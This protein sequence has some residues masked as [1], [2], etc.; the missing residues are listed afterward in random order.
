MLEAGRKKYHLLALRFDG[1]SWQGW[2]IPKK[3]KTV[4]N[5]TQPI[6]DH[7]I[8]VE[9]CFF[10][11][12]MFS[13]NRFSITLGLIYC[14]LIECCGATGVI[15]L[16]TQTMHCYK[17]ITSTLHRCVVLDSSKVGNLKTLVQPKLPGMCQSFVLLSNLHVSFCAARKKCWLVVEPTHL[18]NIRQDGFIFPNFRGENKKIFELPPASYSMFDPNLWSPTSWDLYLEKRRWKHLMENVDFWH[19]PFLISSLAFWANHETFSDETWQWEDGNHIILKK[20][21]RLEKHIN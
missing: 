18:T 3:Y 16:P 11:T 8:Q 1:S 10:P 9:T 20:K 21:L 4:Q 13:K 14:P 15:K 19:L 5:L 7:E 12:K 17:G 6:S 2:R